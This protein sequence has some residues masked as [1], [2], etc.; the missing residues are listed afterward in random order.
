[1]TSIVQTKVS[2][3]PKNEIL[4]DVSSLDK[5]EDGIQI[6]HKKFKVY[7]P[8]VWILYDDMKL[9]AQSL[10]NFYL[11]KSITNI[12]RLIVCT[13]YH[14]AGIKTNRLFRYYF[15]KENKDDT[16]ALVFP[17]LE[18]TF[19]FKFVMYK[20]RLGKWTRKCREHYE[21]MERYLVECLNEW[22]YRVPKSAHKLMDMAT[23]FITENNIKTKLPYAKLK[24]VIPVWQT[25]PPK[26]RN[27]DIYK[28]YRDYY[29]HLI[30]DPF[31]DYA[32]S[33]RDIPEFVLDAKKSLV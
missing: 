16:M 5:T 20:H 4:G 25:I 1:M 7:D 19:Q 9:S 23:Y 26:Y 13:H 30:K 29:A 6:R 28:S 31:N 32:L 12:I 11:N 3:S 27:K 18:T 33:N 22:S 8:C 17:N 2:V 24:T 10:T 21:F 14:F 15:S